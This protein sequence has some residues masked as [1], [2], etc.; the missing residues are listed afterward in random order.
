MWR[1]QGVVK[2]V[3]E[4]YSG[5]FSYSLNWKKIKRPDEMSCVHST[6][7]RLH[8]VPLGLVSP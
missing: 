8:S 2:G 1:S 6:L 5:P 3:W 4:A 7:E